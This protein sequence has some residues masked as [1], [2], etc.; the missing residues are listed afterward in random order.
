MLSKGIIDFDNNIDDRIE[1]VEIYFDIKYQEDIKRDLFKNIIKLYNNNKI[2]S[3]KLPLKLHP[4]FT[5]YNFKII[6]SEDK[7]IDFL[8]MINN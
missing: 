5:K 1:I 8:N 7:Y 4:A 2:V 3:T 6:D